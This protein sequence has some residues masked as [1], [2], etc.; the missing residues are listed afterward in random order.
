MG[1][2]SEFRRKFV[3]VKVNVSTYGLTNSVL[4]LSQQILQ[5]PMAAVCTILWH[6]HPPIS[7]GIVFVWVV[8]AV[9]STWLGTRWSTTFDSVAAIMIRVKGKDATIR[10]PCCSC[11]QRTFWCLLCFRMWLWHDGGLQLRRMQKSDHIRTFLYHTLPCFAGLACNAI[12]LY[13]QQ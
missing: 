11:K 3:F 8:V 4:R 9:S 1:H 6:S 10:L 7:N 2:V 5:L 13:S 12:F